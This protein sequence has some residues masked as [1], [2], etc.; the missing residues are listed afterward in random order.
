MEQSIIPDLFDGL[1]YV[2]AALHFLD[3]YLEPVLA[4][5]QEDAQHHA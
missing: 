1:D 4:N 2:L 5:Y 3:V